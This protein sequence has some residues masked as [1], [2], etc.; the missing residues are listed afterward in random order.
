[1]ETVYLVYVQIYRERIK[2]MRYRDNLRKKKI[3]EAVPK[4]SRELWRGEGE[5]V[6]RFG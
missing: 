2:T 6:R 3:N 1:M 5:S 4:T